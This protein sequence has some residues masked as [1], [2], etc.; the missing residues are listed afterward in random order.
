MVYGLPHNAALLKK[1]SQELKRV[2]GTGG[3]V[4]EEGVELQGDVRPR[5]RDALTK[6]GDAVKG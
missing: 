4:I 6:R 3:T 5:V 1:L 2:C